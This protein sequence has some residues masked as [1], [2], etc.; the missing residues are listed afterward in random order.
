M[1]TGTLTV[2]GAEIHYEVRGAGPPLL[3][4]NGGEA[5]AAMFAPLAALMAEGHTVI[6]FDPR[7]HSRSRLTASPAERR[8]EE[9]G[10][11][12]HLLL[13]ALA[14]GEPAYVFGTSYGAMTGMDLVARHP[15]QV[16]ALVAHEPFVIDLLPDADQWHALFQEVCELHRREGIR[17]AL[18]RLSRAIGVDG[19]PEPDAEALPAPV[20]EMLARIHANVET[21][22]T[23][24]LRS[25][26][27]FRPDTDALRAARFTLALGDE[28][29][30]TLLHRT[31]RTLADR[32]GTEVTGF[33]GGHVGYLTH[34]ADF[35]V[36][37]RG[38]LT[39]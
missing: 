8:I 3:L 29:P 25:F 36:A 35:A 24:E 10:H 1:R 32:V 28:G 34:T 14:G 30:K 9:R 16:R 17:P 26:S 22:L 23:Y 11:D 39:A 38:A 20:R 5:D 6:T 37:L 15:G 21:G 7:G 12:A 4:L 18:D 27:R 2:P 19:P 31:T 13:D 33:P